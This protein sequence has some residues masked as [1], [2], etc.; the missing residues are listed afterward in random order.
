[1]ATYLVAE[2]WPAITRVAE[3]LLDR[4]EL[5]GLRIEALFC[6]CAGATHF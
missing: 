6:C 5:S 1:M 3:A 2:H 4:G